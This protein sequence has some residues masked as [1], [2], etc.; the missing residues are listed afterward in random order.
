MVKRKHKSVAEQVTRLDPQFEHP[1]RWSSIKKSPRRKVGYFFIVMEMRTRR[2]R[3]S[4]E[5]FAKAFH[6]SEIALN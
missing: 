3:N 1:P 2:G 6:K 5:N 4:R